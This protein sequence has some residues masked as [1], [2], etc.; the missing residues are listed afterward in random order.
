M[1]D[2][3]EKID[4]NLSETRDA[5]VATMKRLETIKAQFFEYDLFKSAWNL[6]YT[7]GFYTLLR[8]ILQTNRAKEYMAD[9][10]VQGSLADLQTRM[11]EAQAS[12]LQAFRDEEKEKK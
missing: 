9:E 8:E 7:E 12:W 3:E 10:R 5:I 1:S 2:S 11:E 6:G 4:K